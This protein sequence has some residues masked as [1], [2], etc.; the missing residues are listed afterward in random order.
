MPLQILPLILFRPSFRVSRESIAKL[1]KTNVTS[2]TCLRASKEE[3]VST[4]SV[5]ITATVNAD[6]RARDARLISTNATAIRARMTPLVSMRRVDSS[7]SACVDLQVID[8]WEKVTFEDVRATDA[9]T[10]VLLFCNVKAHFSVVDLHIL[11]V[12]PYAKPPFIVSESDYDFASEYA[13]EFAC[14]LA[15]VS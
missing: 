12:N 11:C 1:T 7:V 14:Y 8:R 6:S 10:V 5:L 3:L 9:H 4:P 13:F 15:S 2:P